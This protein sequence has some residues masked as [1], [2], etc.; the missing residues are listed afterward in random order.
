[1]KIRKGDTVQGSSGEDLALLPELVG[2]IVAVLPGLLED[3]LQ[4]PPLGDG[5]DDPIVEGL[6][7]LGDSVRGEGHHIDVAPI[8][9]DS[10]LDG[11]GAQALPAQTVHTIDVF[12][13]ELAEVREVDNGLLVIAPQDVLVAV[14][15]VHKPH[16]PLGHKPLENVIL[17]SLIVKATHHRKV[18]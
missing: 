9:Q 17:D 6:P 16:R 2:D 7:E 10:L 15:V 11:V 14:I 4:P 13:S 3:V 1:M 5:R 12:P 8:L 18:T